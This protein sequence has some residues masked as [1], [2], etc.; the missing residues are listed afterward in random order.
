M[1]LPTDHSFIICAYKESKYLESCIQ[2][3]QSQTVKTRITISTST[4][5][6]FIEEISKKYSLPLFV[7]HGKSG[8]AGDWNFALSCAETELITLAHQDDVYEPEYTE[9]MLKSMN[10]A[11]KPI[12]YS[13]N[14]SELRNSVKVY[15]NRL[16]NIK[17]MLRIPMRLFP[18]SITARRLSLAFG[19]PICC[20][21]VTYV[22]SIMDNHPFH[23]GLLASL[24]WQQWEELSKEKGSFVYSNKPLMSHRIHEESETSRVINNFSRVDEDYRM[25]LKFWPAPVAR[26][27]AR[28]YSLSEK[29][30]SV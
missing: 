8:I 17:K 22:K 10:A 6:A 15:N 24:D 18:D 7:N 26:F 4:P 14:Y 9:T 21:S 12:F 28:L 2:S 20:P 16:L 29:S 30:N 27:L 23:S 3:L 19:D 25:F 13:T 5:N 1:F 11:K